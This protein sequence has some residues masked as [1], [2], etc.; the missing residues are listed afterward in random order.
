MCAL[1][2][3]CVAVTHALAWRGVGGWPRSTEFTVGH[4]RKDAPPNYLIPSRLWCLPP[5][6]AGLCHCGSPPWRS[7]SLPPPKPA[8]FLPPSPPLHLSCVSLYLLCVSGVSS[9]SR[10]PVL[11]CSPDWWLACMMS[12]LI[13]AL[14]TCTMRCRKH[15][16]KEYVGMHYLEC[17]TL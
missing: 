12:L 14:E 2:F 4:S 15:R 11:P 7:L 10:P 6:G 1:W 16:M 3:R 17:S 13:F 9:M 5:S 8:F